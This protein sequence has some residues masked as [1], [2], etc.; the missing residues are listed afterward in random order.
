MGGVTEALAQVEVKGSNGGYTIRIGP[1]LVLFGIATA[2]GISV[3][4]SYELR[5]IRKDL[6]RVL[7]KQ[8]SLA[9]AVSELGRAPSDDGG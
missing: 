9:G 2:L 3:W 6:A 5:G 8:T 7:A 4:N 1:R